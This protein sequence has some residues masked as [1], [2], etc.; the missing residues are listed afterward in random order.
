MQ[1][2]S[3]SIHTVSWFQTITCVST[4]HFPGWRC[5]RHIRFIVG[6]LAGI[7]GSCWR[8]RECY[9]ISYDLWVF[10]LTLDL[11]LTLIYFKDWNIWKIWSGLPEV[12]DL[13]FKTATSMQYPL[14]PGRIS[15]SWSC[16]H[17]LTSTLEFVESTW[18]L[19]RVRVIFESHS[20]CA[21]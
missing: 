10:P 17:L 12:W 5:I 13:N 11:E 6:F 3:A 14:R 19:Y 9:K 8:R 18:Y 21:Q 15:P 20:A 4:D 16:Y 7:T 1:Y 2:R